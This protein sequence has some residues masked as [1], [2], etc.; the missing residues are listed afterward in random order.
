MAEANEERLPLML[1]KENH[2]KISSIKIQMQTFRSNICDN[3]KATF[4]A[5]ML[6]CFKSKL[7]YKTLY[8][9]S[10]NELDVVI[11][12]SSIEYSILGSL[13]LICSTRTFELLLRVIEYCGCCLL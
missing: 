11:P 8:S 2:E 13:G 3:G 7:N 6:L 12:P 9:I 4:N 10:E 5:L 1:N